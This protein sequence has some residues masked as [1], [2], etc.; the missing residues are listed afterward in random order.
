[1]AVAGL[2]LLAAL[3][4]FGPVLWLA[5]DEE[6][7]PASSDVPALPAGV[8]VTHED[9]QCGSGGCWRELRLRGT[10]GQSAAEIAAGVGLQH[11]TCQARSL[12]DRRRVCSG[13][14]VIGDDVRLYVR[15]DRPLSL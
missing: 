11:E 3:V 12:L 1:M 9:V 10:G 15:F 14:S 8:T 7:V 4:L 13:V 2:V 6:A 5:V